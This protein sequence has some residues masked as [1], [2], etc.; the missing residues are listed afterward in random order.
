M[1]SHDKLNE[2]YN[3]L[4]KAIDISDEMFEK[5][6]K[7]YDALGK[8]IDEETPSYKIS[9][10]PQGSF[11]LGTVVRPISDEDDYDI[12]LVCEFSQQYSLTA[13][14]LKVDVVKPLLMR[15]KR[16]KG[17]I[18]NKR[19]CWHVDYEDIPYFHMDVIPAYADKPIIHI[20]D[21]NEETD[22]YDYIGS[23]PS[24][25]TKWFF[26]RCKKQHTLLYENYVKEHR[27]VVAQADIEKVKRRKVKTPLQR[28]IQLLKL[29]RDI[30]FKN[31]D[32]KDKPVSVIIT[33]IAAQLYQEEDNT[34][35]ALKTILDNARQYILDK[36]RDGQY[37][38]ENPSYLG[39]N[40]ANK[41]NEHAERAAAFFEWIEK[42]KTDLVDEKLTGFNRTEMATNTKQAF[43]ANIG[44]KVFSELATED[45][46]AIKD[47]K[48]KVDPTTGTL[49]NTGT[50]PVQ[51]NHHYGA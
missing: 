25:Y 14:Q 38:I 33:T 36:K 22:V 48:L 50:I 12:D 16:I 13:R 20:T 34:F 41:W 44:V 35:D 9:I 30:M 27:L 45:R 21:H 40:F 19:R 11:A 32:S 6:A 2:L 51:P 29:H 49:S 18:V 43:G 39:E 7:E 47:Q 24:G 1:Y 17:D 4:A 23:N 5:A 37:F 8:W 42:A 15:Y 10:Y 31:R 46:V 26:E 28:A 3:R